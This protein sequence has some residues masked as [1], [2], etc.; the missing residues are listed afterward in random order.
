MFPLF[1]PTCNGRF[2]NFKNVGA[3]VKNP[4]GI[5]VCSNHIFSTIYIEMFADIDLFDFLLNALQNG[6]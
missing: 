5:F 6:H 2:V 4:N 3:I 1:T